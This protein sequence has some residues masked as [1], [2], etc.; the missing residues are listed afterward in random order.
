MPNEEKKW[1]VP[2][3]IAFV[4]ALITGATMLIVGAVQKD[5]ALVTQGVLVVGVAVGIAVPQPMV[6]EK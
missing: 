1:N 3:A 4:G 6:G 5:A 2:S